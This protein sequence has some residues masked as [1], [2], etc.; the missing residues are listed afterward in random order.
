MNPSDLPDLDLLVAPLTNGDPAGEPVSY[1]A[2][3]KFEAARKTINPNDYAPNDPLRPAEPKFADWPVIVQLATDTLTESSKDLMTAARLVEALTKLAG[4]AGL[5]HGMTLMMRLVDEAWDRLHPIIEDGDIE[6]RAAAFNWLDDPSR[7]ARFPFS[8]RGI[9]LASDAN[10]D[11][12]WLGWK[13]SQTPPPNDQFGNPGPPW[14]FPERFEKAV[15]AA[16]RAAVQQLVDDI[17]ACTGVLDQLGSVLDQRLADAAPS[18]SEIRL[19]ITEVGKLATSMLAKKGP[20]PIAATTAVVPAETIETAGAAPVPSSNGTGA[21]PARALH[22]RDDAYRQLADAASLLQSLEPHSPIPY[23]IQRAVA[24]GRLPFPE[25]M[26]FMI[27]DA[28]IL[29]QMSRELG[30]E[31]TPT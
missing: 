5:K 15:A 13:E 6:V 11:L 22:T 17:A 24:L 4:F 29:E 19:A 30:L 7:G 16:P 28:G 20:A 2:R 1:V 14:K 9:P 25:L 8:I 12:N 27:R 31:P 21:A 3:E 18:L 26:K 23:M 10:G